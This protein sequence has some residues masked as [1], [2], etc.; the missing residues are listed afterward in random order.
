MLLQAIGIN[1]SKR[2]V[3]RLLIEKQ[4]GFLTET[5][6]V[7]RA[8]LQT[9]RWVSVD[10]T[11]ARHRTTTVHGRGEKTV[12]PSPGQQVAGWVVGWNKKR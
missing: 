2:Q 5:R 10:D 6:E 11:G 12:G 8:G 7:L 9:A 4:D 3:M 1:I